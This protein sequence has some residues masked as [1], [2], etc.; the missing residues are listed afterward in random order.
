MVGLFFHLIYISAILI[1]INQIYLFNNLEWMYK[2][3]YII[4]GGIIYPFTYDM[5]QMYKVGIREYFSTAQNWFDFIFVWS[6]LFMV[7]IMNFYPTISPFDI[8]PKLLL[9]STIQTSIPKTFFFLRV[10]ERL[11]YIVT[12]LV[13]V[14]GDLQVFM[15]FYVL[16]L[17]MFS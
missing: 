3:H 7:I 16:L 10:F 4:L 17:F 6:G 15:F 11:S 13:N 8:L 5:I 9:L 14:T 2:L 12:M 1:Y